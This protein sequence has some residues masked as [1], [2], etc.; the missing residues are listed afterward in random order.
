MASTADG[1]KGKY[2]ILSISS[3]L[4]T[5]DYKDV[6]CLIDNGLAGTRTVSTTET[7]CGTAKATGSPAYTVSGS[8]AA[9]SN[10]GASE[11]SA[12][13]LLA[14]FDSGAAFL[15]KLA[16]ITTPADYYRQGQGFFSSY[17]ETAPTSDDVKA[18]FVIEVTS[19][20]D[21]DSAA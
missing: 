14:L 17:N 13:E 9:N 16:H 20:I 11:I 4:V 10:P 1:I 18:D 15:W 21:A 3:N 7:K 5:P 2:V 12:N 19:T 8:L 6:V